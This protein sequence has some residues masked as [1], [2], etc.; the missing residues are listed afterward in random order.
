LG[1]NARSAPSP[2][3]AAG[4]INTITKTGFTITT[5]AGQIVTITDTPS[6]KFASGTKSTVSNALVK[7]ESVLALG[8]TSSTANSATQV[9]V[10]TP[11]SSMFVTS[12]AVVDFT[13]GAPTDLKQV[14]KIPTDW[15]QGSGAIISGTAADEAIEAALAK[16]P[17]GIVDRAVKLSDGEYNVHYIGVNWPHHVVV[18]QDFEVVGAE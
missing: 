6:T 16:Y 17:G 12:S 14:G 8:I 18:S 13:R 3:G 1:S 10:E 11:G 5:S 7:D 4:I 2:G 15:T 9:I